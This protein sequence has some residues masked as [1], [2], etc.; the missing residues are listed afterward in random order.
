MSDISKE[1]KILE[2]CQSAGNVKALFGYFK[3]TGPGWWIAAASLSAGS[4]I[5]SVGLG[6]RLGL[7]GLWI[8]AAAMLLGMFTLF[9]IS[10]ITLNTQ[11]SLFVILKNDWN[12]SLATWLAVS[13]IIT[14]FTWC[15]PQFRLGADAVVATLLPSL[16]NKGGRVLIA[17]VLL[18]LSVGLSFIYEK[19]GPRSSIFTWTIKLLVLFV[20]FSAISSVILFLPSSGIS[21]GDIFQGL[22]PSYSLLIEPSPLFSTLLE[23]SGEMKMFWEEKILLKQ[24]E[25]ALV[26]FSS[27]LGVNLMFALPLILLNRNWR[28]SHDRF[29]KFNLFTTGFLPFSIVSVC[30]TLLSTIAF[31]QKNVIMPDVELLENAATVDLLNQRIVHEIG[32]KRFSDMA[33]FQQDACMVALS[34][35]EKRLASIIAG[36]S[37]KQWIASLSQTGGTYFTYLLGLTI[38]AITLSTI[39]IL[40][41]I[42]G[43]LVCEVLG[44]PHKGPAFQSGSLLLA[45]AS[46]GPFVWSGQDNWVSDPTYFISL[47]ILPFALL[48]FSLVLNNPSI[49]GRMRPKGIGGYFINTGIILSFIFI[50]SSSIYIVWN[51][52]W[53]S[54][55][56]GQVLISL[57]GV[58]LLIGHFSLRTQKLSK[59]LEGLDAKINRITDQSG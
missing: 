19:Q 14:S 2:S 44:K 45:I 6:Q 57:I 48:S 7:D 25:L 28:R 59:R 15:M 10:Q 54:F 53:G 33:P 38:F 39:V 5:G 17:I 51:E 29:S 40:M 35:D 20:I 36:K 22:L 26:C 37:V 1:V 9:A 4:L 13:A 56:I 31:Q 52:Y 30:L 43:H 3:I 27:T 32:N 42:N 8:Q 21:F 34:N 46:I 18:I 47:A 16:D 11:Q 58:L 12:K 55:P 24:K 23:N 50:G 41:I 49:M